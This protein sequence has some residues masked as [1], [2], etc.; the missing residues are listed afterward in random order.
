M[1]ALA[2]PDVLVQMAI[3]G[4]LIPA[5]LTGI[6]DIGMAAVPAPLTLVTSLFV[7]GG[8]LHLILNM[9]FLLIVG[10]MVEWVVGPV[11]LLLIFAAGGIAGGLLQVLVTPGSTLPVI[12]ASGAVAAVFACYATLF[13]RKRP[14]ARRILGINVSSEL[15]TALWF[16]AAWIGLQLMTGAAF[17]AGGGG[18]AIWAHIGGF[19]AGLLIAQPL[20]RRPKSNAL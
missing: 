2:G 18:I 17:N 15:L 4:G 6:V 8:W 12:G 7:H 9:L 5:R 1:A 16:A 14:G 19:I 20:A 11:K 10:R 13:A 3:R